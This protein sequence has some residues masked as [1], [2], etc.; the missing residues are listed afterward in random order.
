MTFTQCFMSS[1]QKYAS[2]D[3]IDV[4]RFVDEDNKSICMKRPSLFDFCLMF[5]R[6][7]EAYLSFF[8]FFFFFF[9]FYKSLPCLR[10]SMFVYFLSI[11]L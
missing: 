3:L 6:W 4:A 10:F 1:L 2:S 8:F 5:A 9:S 11:F 7:I